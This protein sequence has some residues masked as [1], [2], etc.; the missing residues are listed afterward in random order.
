MRHDHCVQSAAS[1]MG[2]GVLK[3]GAETAISPDECRYL[4]ILYSPAT[5]PQQRV[6]C[7]WFDYL[8]MLY[9]GRAQWLKH[10][11]TQ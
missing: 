4:C 9:T 6:T 5:R 2:W 8:G 3:P 7:V 10:A 1:S 11:P